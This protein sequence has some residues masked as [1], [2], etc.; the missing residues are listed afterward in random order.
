MSCP[1]C[2]PGVAHRHEGHAYDPAEDC[3]VCQ[4]DEARRKHEL[5]QQTLDAAKLKIE[6]L[7]EEH[8]KLDAV[9]EALADERCLFWG[10]YGGTCKTSEPEK[11]CVVCEVRAAL[12]E[13]G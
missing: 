10:K 9:R 2:G 12:G 5:V 6:L 8:T 3:P 11:A 13:E 4:R 7:E 1:C